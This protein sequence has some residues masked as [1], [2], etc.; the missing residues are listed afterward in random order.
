MAR[1]VYLIV[2]DYFRILIILLMKLSLGDMA[3]NITDL[4]QWIWLMLNW[5]WRLIYLWWWH[6]Q[7]Q[8]LIFRLDMWVLRV[9]ELEPSDAIHLEVRDIPIPINLE[10]FLWV[11]TQK[12]INS[13]SKSSIFDH[14]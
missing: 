10:S 5:N 11:L 7:W 9:L 4:A 1:I 2:S 14:I 8:L 6:W 3:R 12:D 13:S